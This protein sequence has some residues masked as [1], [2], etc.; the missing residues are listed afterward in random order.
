M[1]LQRKR[2]AGRVAMHEET[3]NTKTPHTKTPHTKTDTN[4]AQTAFTL[5]L[6][7]I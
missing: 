7:I 1:P 3:P 4:S 6:P 2:S 5:V